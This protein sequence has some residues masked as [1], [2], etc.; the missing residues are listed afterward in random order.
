MAAHDIGAQMRAQVFVLKPASVGLKPEGK[1]GF[2]DGADIAGPDGSIAGKVTSCGIG[3]TVGGP[4][5][6]GYV[7]RRFAAAGTAVL[8][9]VDGKELPARI[10]PLPFV[11]HRYRGA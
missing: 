2:Q 10:A 6:M 5:A 11:P 8:V 3:P 7:E 4:I 9:A 1:Q